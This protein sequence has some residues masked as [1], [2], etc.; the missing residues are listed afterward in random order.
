MAVAA[1][2]AAFVGDAL[3]KVYDHI[4]LVSSTELLQLAEVAVDVLITR[5]ASLCHGTV[6]DVADACRV[7]AAMSAYQLARQLADELDREPSYR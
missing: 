4:Q 6:G 2:H 3:A 5:H 1:P 7:T